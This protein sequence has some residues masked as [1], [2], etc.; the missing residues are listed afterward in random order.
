MPLFSLFPVGS[1][2][3]S[4]I[5]F[6]FLLS[7]LKMVCMKC[8]KARCHHKTCKVLQNDGEC[9]VPENFHTSPMEDSL[10]CTPHPSGF[11]LPGG[12]SLTSA[13]LRNFQNF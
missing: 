12:L 7:I 1:H 3:P 8:V 4:M 5:F 2:S 13:L 6:S 10:I 11:S 9:V